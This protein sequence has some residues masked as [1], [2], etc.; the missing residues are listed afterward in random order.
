MSERVIGMETELKSFF[1]AGTGFFPPITDAVC[2]DIARDCGGARIISIPGGGRLSIAEASLRVGAVIDRETTG[3]EPIAIYS[4]SMGGLI[5][6]ECALVRP[7]VRRVVAISTPFHG[8]S[9]AWA[10]AALFGILPGMRDI[11]PGSDYMVGLAERLPELAPRLH[12]IYLG[13]DHLIKPH[14]SCHVTGADNVMI[15]NLRQYAATYDQIYDTEL[16]TGRTAH[17]LEVFDSTIRDC[18][19]RTRPEITLAA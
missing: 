15:G 12:S 6:A 13:S 18:I 1:I 5:A 17:W 11:A 10:V 14:H 2:R 16:L 9:I 4:H 8:T 19:C 7:Q 3:E